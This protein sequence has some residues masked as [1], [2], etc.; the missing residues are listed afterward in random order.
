MSRCAY[1]TANC[2]VL[3]ATI[4]AHASPI[5][6]G[7]AYSVSFDATTCVACWGGGP[8]PTVTING[9][10]SVVPVTGGQFYYP[11]YGAYFS[12]ADMVVGMTGT[13]TI[14]CND[15][16]GC[17]GDGTYAMSLAQ[18]GPGTNTNGWSTPLGDG[19]WLVGLD[20][21]YLVL[22]AAGSGLDTRFINDNSSNLLQ[23]ESSTTHEGT[24]VP[25]HWNAVR[26]PES[27]S[28]V[29]LAIGAV[30]IVLVKVQQRESRDV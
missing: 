19:S 22:S 13:A 27:S 10:L 20:P 26:V 2:L 25:V 29:L 5:P 17:T 16:A 11:F 1:F 12:S 15:L 4:P 30:A 14:D 3:F 9:T 18:P 6:V 7:E 28:I 8:L 24:Q 23:W 21:E